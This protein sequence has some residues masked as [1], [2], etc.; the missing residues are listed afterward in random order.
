MR[1]LYFGHR[2]KWILCS[3]WFSYSYKLTVLSWRQKW[4]ISTVCYIYHWIFEPKYCQAPECFS[5]SSSITRNNVV[6]NEQFLFCGSRFLFSPIESSSSSV[7]R[8]NGQSS[9]GLTDPTEEAVV[10]CCSSCWDNSYT[11]FLCC[12][13]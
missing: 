10:L 1:W 9:L 12:H 6:T 7:V 8:P 4:H 3:T 2:I 5:N 11:T 13:F